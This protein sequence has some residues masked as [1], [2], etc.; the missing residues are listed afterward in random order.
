MNPQK[1]DEFRATRNV[2]GCTNHVRWAIHESINCG[3][4]SRQFTGSQVD[5]GKR[6]KNESALEDCSAHFVYRFDLWGSSYLA[7]IQ[8]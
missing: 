3:T 2:V 7:G 1:S 8:G 5:T 4:T 6:C